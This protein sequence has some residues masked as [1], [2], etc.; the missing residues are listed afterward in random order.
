MMAH[1]ATLPP[2]VRD[3]LIARRGRVHLFDRLDPARTALVVI[4][5]QDLFTDP[6]SDR[7]IPRARGIV[8]AINRAATSLRARGGTV[9]WVQTRLSGGANDWRL[10]FEALAPSD[11]GNDVRRALTPGAPGYA[12]DAG[13]QTLP[14]DLFAEKTR[15]SAFFP[16]ASPLPGMLRDRGIDTVI[17]AGT[18][19]NV[20]CETSARDAA[21]DDFRVILLTDGNATRTDAEHTAALVTIA[22]SFGDAQSIDE[23]FAHLDA[24]A[25]RPPP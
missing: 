18:L 16:G 3:T 8:P 25:A 20:C 6:G 14:G 2:E 23:V 22:L 4:D 1:P 11:A 10:Y 7:C 12:L 21:M 15:F 19:T 13:L 17:F 24:G 9:A 5:M